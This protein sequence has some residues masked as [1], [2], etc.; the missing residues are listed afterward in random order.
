MLFSNA[1]L[2]ICNNLDFDKWV[3]LSKEIS[4]VSKFPIN[5]MH[6]MFNEKKL[7]DL[8]STSH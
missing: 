2:E 1:C 7:I 5:F 4:N 6:V 8:I 3:W